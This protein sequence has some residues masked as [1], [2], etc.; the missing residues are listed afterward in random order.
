MET[1]AERI[2][3]EFKLDADYEMMDNE[4]AMMAQIKIQIAEQ[5]GVDTSEITDM[6]LKRG[7]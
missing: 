1:S 7:K 2:S 6:E 5:I 3:V 4:A